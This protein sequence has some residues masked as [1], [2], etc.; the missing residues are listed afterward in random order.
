M[1]LRAG[2]DWRENWRQTFAKLQSNIADKSVVG[3]FLGDE[4]MY[5]GVSL[6][7]TTN[8]ADL[9]KK[10]WPE[11]IIYQ[12]E[13]PSIG[14]CNFNKLNETVFEGDHSMI[15]SSIDWWGYDHCAH[16]SCRL[17]KA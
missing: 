4:R 17:F 13:A 6:L 15:P 8:M 9:I 14:D 10:D 16:R 3:I 12:N 1:P 2:P 11:S 5:F 7:N